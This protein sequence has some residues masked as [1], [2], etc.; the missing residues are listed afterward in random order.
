METVSFT[1]ALNNTLFLTLARVIILQRK[2]EKIS[3]KW[4][5]EKKMLQVYRN[6]VHFG[7]FFWY[8]MSWRGRVNVL[9]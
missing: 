9:G 4:D 6:R 2:L 5:S 3:Q 8:G 7:N 1:C